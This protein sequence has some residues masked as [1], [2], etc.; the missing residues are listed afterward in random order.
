MTSGL[1]SWLLQLSIL[2]GNLGDAPASLRAAESARALMERACQAAP[3]NPAFQQ[4]SCGA[5]ERIAK[6]RWGMDQRAA[7]LAAHREA[8]AI[9]RRLFERDPSVLSA[10]IFLSKR[11]V[12]LARWSQEHGDWTAKAAALAERAILWPDD[13]KELTSVAGHFE[14]IAQAIG[15]GWGPLSPREEEQRKHYVAEAV[16]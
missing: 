14:E 1:A 6:T 5:W 16:R 9:G 4:W 10:R 2:F 8:A 3:D 11:Y 7:A 15:L 12:R 13:A